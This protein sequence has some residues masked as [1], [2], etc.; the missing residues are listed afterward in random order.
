MPGQG[1]A[2]PRKAAAV[3]NAAWHNLGGSGSHLGKSDYSI[4]LAF[5]PP[6]SPFLNPGNGCGATAMGMRRAFGGRAKCHFGGK[7][8]PARESLGMAFYPRNIPFRN[9]DEILPTQN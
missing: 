3:D 9:L 1:T 4:K 8:M 2:P 6:Y 7:V 5:L